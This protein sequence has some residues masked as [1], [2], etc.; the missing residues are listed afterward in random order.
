MVTAVLKV[1]AGKT[2]T[3]TNQEKSQAEPEHRQ[4]RRGS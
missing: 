4:Q 2:P 1:D 3:Q